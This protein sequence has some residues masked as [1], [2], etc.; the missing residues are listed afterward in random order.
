MGT[1]H[2]A[3]RLDSLPEATPAGVETLCLGPSLLTAGATQR[4]ARLPSSGQ[5]TWEPCAGPAG[6]PGTLAICKYWLNFLQLFH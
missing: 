4:P 1:G 3:W 6:L 5:R 2:Q